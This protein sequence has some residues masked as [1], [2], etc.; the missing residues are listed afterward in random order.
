MNPADDPTSIGNL[1]LRMRAVLPEALE[2][3]LLEQATHGGL[4]GEL[5]WG[6][7]YA[8]PKDVREALRLQELVKSGHPGDAALDLIDRDLEALQAAELRCSA[9]IESA[10]Q[11][12]R[13]LG[14]PSCEWLRARST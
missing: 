4:L 2:A 10:K 12:A 9:A 7:G 13:D 11:D 1:L 6:L 14:E 3:A 8:K 5:L